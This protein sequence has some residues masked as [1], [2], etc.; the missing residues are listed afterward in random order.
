MENH[1]VWNLARSKAKNAL[2]AGFFLA[3]LSFLVLIFTEKN[4]RTTTDLLVSQN[5]VG[6]TDYYALSKSAD[7][8]TNILA[9]SVYSEKF[10]D[11][12]KNSG[13][14]TGAF[15]PTDKSR[16]LK[17]WKKIADISHTP[18]LGMIRIRVFSDSQKQATEISN[19]II[20][21]LTEKNSLFLGRGQELEVKTLNSPI[22]EK[23]PGLA[24]IILVIGGGFIVGAALEL[25]RVWLK[26]QGR[27]RDSDAYLESLRALHSE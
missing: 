5:Q 6:F 22:W 18:N 11:E 14:E 16:R 8:L 1:F 26:N 17:E 12:L 3:A 7:Y 15:L 2:L 21:V 27:V 25:L 24:H 10:L 19:G 20:K 9:E 23:N 4:F 13:V